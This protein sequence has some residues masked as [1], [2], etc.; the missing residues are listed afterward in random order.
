MSSRR[1]LSLF[2]LAAGFAR[3]DSTLVLNEI[4]Y[5]PP[6]GDQLEW[7]ELHNQMAVDLDVSGWYFGEGI[8]FVFPAGSIIPGGGYV[9]VAASPTALAS[10]SGY[11]GAL[12][13]YAGRLDDDGEE[14]ELR[15][16]SHRVMDV[17]DYKSS[18]RWPVGPAGSGFS[19]AK[20]DPDLG[21]G[22]R[23][24]WT[25]SAQAGGTPGE[26]NFPVEGGVGGFPKDL[27]A[28]WS[29]DQ[30]SGSMQDLVGGNN[31][32]VGSGTTRVAG[33]VGQGAASFNNST[34][35]FISVGS[36]VNN[37]FSVTTG[38]A[39]EALVRPT[40]SGVENDQDEIFR[41]EDGDRRILL[42]FQNDGNTNGF[43]NPPVGPGPVLSFG[44]NVGGVYSELDMLLDGLN[45]RPSLAS[46]L[47]G[48]THHVAAVYDAATGQKSI[49]WDGT[50][51]F[52][53]NLGAGNQVQ[54]GGG[55]TAYIGNTSGRAEPFTGVIDEV[56]IWKKSLSSQEVV[57]HRSKSQAGKT[58]FEEDSV[59]SG[60]AL[61][62][63]FNE[64]FVSG[65]ASWIELVN[66]GA[67]PLNVTGFVVRGVDVGREAVLPA[68]TIPAGGFLVLTS[69]QLGF[70]LLAGDALILFGTGKASLIDAVRLEDGLHAR[71][72]DRGGRWQLPDHAT[73]GAAN[74]FAF[75]AEIVI[76]EIQYHPRLQTD[77]NPPVDPPGSWIELFNR[78]AQGVD[79]SGW[80]LAEGANFSFPVGTSLAAG[81]YLVVAED[82]GYMGSLH[83]GVNVLGNLAERL[84]RRGAR[85][86]L[87]DASGNLADE[88]Q[89]Y[90]GGRWPGYA[91]GGGSTLELRDPD[92]DN[93]RAEAWAASDESG[94]SAWKTYSYVAT[95]AAGVGPSQWNEFVMGLLGDGE[96]LL[97]DVHV[98]ETPDT[99]PR[100]LLQNGTF[101][102]GA[103]KWRLLGNHSH[104]LVV[105]A[106]DDP[107]RS[108]LHLVATGATEHMHNHL[109]TTLAGGARV[110]NGRKYEVSFDARWLAGSN[111]LN[112]R[113]YFNRTPRTTLLEV[114]AV[115]GTPGARNS[116][117]EENIGP[118]FDSFSH[119]PVVPDLGQGVT[120]TAVIGDP[121]G[122]ATATLWY[123]VNSAAWTSTPMS[124]AGSGKWSGS[125]PGQAT[126]ATVQFYLEAVDTRGA[127]ATF[128]AAGRNSRALYRVK[129]GQAVLGRV[130]NLRILMTATDTTLLHTPTNVMSNDRL[131]ATLI[132]DERQAFY[133]VGIR[134]KGSERGRNVSGR[135][136]FNIRLDPDRKFRGVHE[137]IQVDRSGG[138]KFGGPFGQDEIVVKHVS[139]HAGDVPCMY[140]DLIRVIA[141]RTAQTG[142]A[143]LIMAAY[144]DVFL[145]SQFPD[146][147]SGQAFELELI[148]SPTS[149]VNGNVESLKLPEP[150]SVTGVDFSNL[151]NDKET[152]RWNFLIENNRDRDD[153]SGLIQ[154]GKAMA[155][156]ATTLEAATGAV[157]D[158]DEWMRAFCV[159]S[160][161]G[162]NDAYTRGNNHNLIVYQRP[163]DGKFL[164]FPWD[165]DFSWVLPT[166]AALWGDQNLGRITQLNSN[167]R[168]FYCHLL[169]IINS[170]FNP[171]YM[172]RW[173]AH[174]GS[175]AGQDYS[176]ILTFIGQRRTFV[177]GA[178]PAKVPFAIT[179]NG[180][181]DLTV[182]TTSIALEG[183]AWFDVKSLFVEGHDAPLDPTW[184]GPSKWKATIPLDAGRNELT[185][186]GFDR[187]GDI[188]AS[189]SIVVTSSAGT[190]APILSAV[191]PQV[192]GPGATVRL[193]GTS[194]VAGL[195]VFFGSLPASA[196]TFDPGTDPGTI[197]AT[198]PA[199]PDGPVTVT[200]RNPD[201][202]SSNGI[203]ATVRSS[204]IFVRGDVS[205]DGVVD[206]SDVLRLVFHLYLGADIPCQDAADTNNNEVLDVADA[207]FLLN[208]LYRGGAAPQSP[209]PSPGEDTGA[210]GVLG[211]GSGV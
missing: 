192:F 167:R 148:Y 207:I 92:A 122:V 1:I 32:T 99:T 177:L 113:L 197:L 140:D 169:D 179:T 53:V 30:G 123:S 59:A 6:G 93:S 84:S 82:V 66:S 117:F 76:N 185:I 176:S 156:P 26:V 41:K 67:Q 78:S 48:A 12:G 94:R 104:G 132:Y 39:V 15:N 103:D 85:I 17:L 182:E 16:Q 163:G 173:T 50:L 150:D 115:S 106:P 69:A 34:T 172:G 193:T 149:T 88:V 33:L 73:Q 42:S 4:M 196:I 206:L 171:E 164:A 210:G 161:C 65:G 91:D 142:S 54:S 63:A 187:A 37:A 77:L 38:I 204:T 22:A 154:L 18:G 133:D 198:V 168:L 201:G 166:N 87:L 152:Y 109:E 25:V 102:N 75:H 86:E 119:D 111:Q 165:M 14:L 10:A 64:V 124:S 40:W 5:Q 178:I 7:V 183:N 19:L 134:L 45:G 151:G 209:F 2:L 205:I 160:L 157:M 174:Y 57:Q 83:P 107:G 153:Y 199:A 55:T 97:D 47:D 184:T 189:D 62:I 81:G 146:G 127:V 190:P 80:R 136:G 90:D 175:L 112:T 130:H 95:A 191:D 135:V 52:S 100:E 70:S 96:V 208:Y 98:V 194:F 116:R 145:S 118:T 105:V 27:I 8:D 180:G 137:S 36:G 44:I 138:W 181:A 58:Y 51:A 200:V 121:E 120:V 9:V 72:P 24:S 20:R 114:P 188:I 28:Y 35:A 29:L 195:Q 126:P 89:Y 211:C 49:Y 13:P 43:S 79:L 31:G 110:V 143:I 108:V 186:Y 147:G 129:D 11:S 155:Q 158:L 46:V 68:G 162:I 159:Y 170:T 101:A 3:A 139:A 71:A 125:I 21:S 202:R 23:A 141:P 61:P 128:P 131:G 144:G 74:S 203:Q 60:P 56:A